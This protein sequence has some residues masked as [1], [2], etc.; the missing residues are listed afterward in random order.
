MQAETRHTPLLAVLSLLLAATLW[1]TFWY[2]LRL[3]EAAGLQGLWLT[4]FIYCG[5]LV[6]AVP[7][8]V[9]QRRQLWLQPGVM[10]G[11]A[12]SSG[13]CN[14]AFIL[15]MLEGEVLR[16]LLLFYL[17]PFW[18]TLLA[19]LVLKE[20]IAIQA[21][22]ILFLSVGGAAIMLWS[23]EVG[24]PWPQSRADWYAIS[25]GMAFA[26]TN[27]FIHMGRQLS[28]QTKAA[29]AWLGVLFIAVTFILLTDTNVDFTNM[30]PV[31]WALAVGVVIMSIMTFSVVY[32]VSNMPVHRSAVILLF[33]VVAGA[34]SA[35]LLTNERLSTQEWIGGTI[36]IAAAYLAAHVPTAARASQDNK[37]SQA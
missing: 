10:L 4:V 34:I 19:V 30:Q 2:P 36:V 3:L 18:A 13:W 6:F 23:P 27:M 28:M 7:I 22:M 20:K 11:I 16:V 31:Y 14:T 5:T 8:L 35:F 12:L 21:Y 32:G 15:A 37:D 33:E 9:R 24:Y 17:S 29:F 26:V 1:G 25:S